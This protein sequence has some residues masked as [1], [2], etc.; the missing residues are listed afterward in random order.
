MVEVLR[1]FG[2]R[3]LIDCYIHDCQEGLCLVTV[4]IVS[5][6]EPQELEVWPFNTPK[7]S[8]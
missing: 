1:V 7:I 5:I 3:F 6:V 4:L 8:K 2:P